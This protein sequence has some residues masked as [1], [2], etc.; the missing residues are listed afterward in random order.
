MSCNALNIISSTIFIFSG[1]V[2]TGYQVNN[3]YNMIGKGNPQWPQVCLLS[4][5][6]CS[7]HEG[8]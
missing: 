2:I 6:V 5:L 4:P 3:T 1:R 7:I 8:K